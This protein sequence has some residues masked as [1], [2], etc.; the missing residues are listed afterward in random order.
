M[1]E[2]TAAT[3]RTPRNGPSTR[4]LVGWTFW[5][6]LAALWL[7]HLPH[8]VSYWM[9]ALAEKASLEGRT[10]EALAWVERAKEWTPKSLLPLKVAGRAMQKAGKLDDLGRIDLILQKPDLTPTE[11]A[12]LHLE[13]HNI[14]K[15]QKRWNE[16]IAELDEAANFKGELRPSQER[17][18]LLMLAGGREDEARREIDQLLA[19]SSTDAQRAQVHLFKCEF[20]QVRSEWVEALKEFDAAAVLQP[21]LRPSV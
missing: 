1:G 2:P 14:L 21:T 10:D 18:Q 19:A 9:L 20:H 12:D 11:K 3:A 16:A 7:I 15:R 6:C 13:K 4:R 8:E 5:F 17:F